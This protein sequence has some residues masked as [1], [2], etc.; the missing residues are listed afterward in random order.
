MSND[1]RFIAA[2]HRVEALKGFYIHLAIFCLVMLGLV[3]LNLAVSSSWWVQ[4]P[5]FGWGIGLAAHAA[6]VFLPVGL[7]GSDWEKRKIEQL[8]RKS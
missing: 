5:L 2:K 8:M 1:P 6:A 3:G 7:F 4:W